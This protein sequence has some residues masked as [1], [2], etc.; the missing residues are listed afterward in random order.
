[1]VH[2]V[3]IHKT[4]EAGY[5]VVGVFQHRPDAL[6]L[7]NAIQRGEHQ[8]NLAFDRRLE[9]DEFCYCTDKPLWVENVV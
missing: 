5:N 4:G 3:V 8:Y 7:Q 6:A 1:M 9:E 2:L